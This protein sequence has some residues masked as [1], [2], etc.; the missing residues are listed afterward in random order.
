MVVN[1]VKRRYD[2]LIRQQHAEGYW[3][4][5]AINSFKAMFADGVVESEAV[6]NDLDK[7]DRMQMRK[8]YA[9]LLAL[10]ILEQNFEDFKKQS[11]LIVQKAKNYLKKQG[12]NDIFQKLDLLYDELLLTDENITGNA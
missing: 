8:V 2:S 12:V 9:T 3:E 10:F 7:V 6:M 4:D 1:E 11:E 5:S